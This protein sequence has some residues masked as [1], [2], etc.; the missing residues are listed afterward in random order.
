MIIVVG[1][2]NVGREYDNTFHNIGFE[3]ADNLALNI[4]AVFTKEK[5]K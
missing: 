1:L 4:G 3:V 2:G 5:Y